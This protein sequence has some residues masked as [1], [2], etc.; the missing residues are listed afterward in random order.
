MQEEWSTSLAL[1]ALGGGVQELSCI[2]TQS[3]PRLFFFGV[4]DSM[5]SDGVYEESFC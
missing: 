2:V 5:L 4:S 3:K 1:L